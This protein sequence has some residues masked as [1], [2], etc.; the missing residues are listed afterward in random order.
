VAA[1]P[2]CRTDVTRCG[3]SQTE[4]ATTGRADPPARGSSIAAWKEKPAMSR[5]RTATDNEASLRMVVNAPEQLS[6]V[7]T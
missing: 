2:P 6:A 5:S 1:A 3:S 4:I 7:A